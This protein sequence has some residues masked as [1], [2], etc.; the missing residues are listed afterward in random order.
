MVTV[1]GPDGVGTFVCVSTRRPLNVRV[2]VPPDAGTVPPGRM[3]LV[4]ED[5]SVS[6]GTTETSSTTSPR[7]EFLVV[8]TDVKLPPIESV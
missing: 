2:A 7:D 5:D 3:L 6:G 1:V 8:E 4:V